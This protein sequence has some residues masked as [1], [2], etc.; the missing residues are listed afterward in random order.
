MDKVTELIKSINQFVSKAGDEENLVDV[1][2]DFPGSDSIPHYV[3]EYEAS[4]AGM[5]R[6]QR[7]FFLNWYQAF[8]AKDDEVSLDVM[9]NFFTY[10]LFAADEF[11]E[12][13]GIET[14]EFLKMT[15]EELSSTIMQSIDRE[16]AFNTLSQRTLNWIDRWSADLSSIMK[17]NTHNQIEKILREGIESGASIDDIEMQLADL[18]QFDRKR[19]RKTAI[20]EV[21]TAS[22]VSLYESFMQ[23]PAVVGKRWKHSGTKGITPRENHQA[24]DGVV[25]PVEEPFMIPD[26]TE[27]A[28]YPRDPNLTAKERVSCH[29]TIGPVVD[30]DIL[31]LSQEEKEE[32]RQQTLAEMAL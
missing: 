26:S 8:I 32:I 22:S 13:F 14:A 31:G 16:V 12:E 17:L 20:T 3:E 21:L 10:N 27:V 7:K 15:I 28:M 24:L 2:A 19:A 25:V 5:L 18:P 30:E 29:C 11:A 1:I 6:K 9:L 4:V 23:S